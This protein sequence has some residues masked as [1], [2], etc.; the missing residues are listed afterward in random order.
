M[1]DSKL[2]LKSELI[3]LLTVKSM[4]DEK[5]IEVESKIKRLKEEE[6]EKEE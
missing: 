4:V 1:S 3:G 5:I 2:I 6:R